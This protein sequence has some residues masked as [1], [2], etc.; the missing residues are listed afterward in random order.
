MINIIGPFDP[1]HDKHKYNT[2]DAFTILA[3]IM[4][5]FT[6]PMMK[7]YKAIRD[8]YPDCLLF[9]RMG[10]FYELFF[11]DATIGAQVLDITL[12]GRPNGKNGRTPMAGV[13][14]HAVDSYLS[15]LVK[16]G[17]KVAI[18][19][20]LS[21]PNKKGLV[22]RDVIRI[23]TPGTL[24]D[25]K[26]LNKK[27]HNYIISLAL[28]GDMLALAT[29]D[30]ST[31]DV[32]TMQVTV[33][34]LKVS[35][36]NELA[37]LHP[38]ECILSEKLY[39]DGEL[40]K[41]LKAEQGLNIFLFREWDTYTSDASTFLKKHFHVKTLAAFGIDDKPLAT[42]A[43]AALIGY[44]KTTQKDNISHIK[45]ISLA[46]DED[47]VVLDRSTMVNLE[48][49][50]TIRDHDTKGSL[51]AVMDNTKTA[52]GG[53]LLRH[54]LLKP[55]TNE[56]EITKRYD[57]VDTLLTNRSLSNQLTELLQQIPDIER[58]VSRLSVGIGNARDL[59]TLKQA[60]ANVIQI[61]SILRHSGFSPESLRKPRK[62]SGPYSQNDGKGSLL[63]SLTSQIS[64]NIE[65][66]ISLI[67]QTIADEP[68]VS[69]REGG[70]IKSGVN[71]QLDKLRKQI[72]GGKEW[73]AELETQE[74]ERTGISSL[75]VRFNKVFGFYIEISK[76]NQHLAPENYI[77]K[78]TL[79][80]GER[81][82]TEELKKQE[83]II[84]RAEAT[85]NDMEY[86]MFQET[87]AK[88][89]EHTEIMKQAAQSI[90]AIDC[91][92]NFAFI[93]QKYNYV[94]PK[95]IYSGELKIKQGR[96][97][98]VEQ[99]LDNT[100][101]VPNDVLLDTNGHQLILITGPNM[102]GKSVFLRQVAL[103][104]LMAQMGSFVPAEQAYVSLVDRIFVR[105]GAADVITSGLSTFM[106][107]MMETAY[108]L[109]NATK[110]SLIIMDEIGRGTSTYDGISI[111]WAVAEYLV[112]N[113]EVT[114]KT[115]FATHY[116]ELT[117]LE[118]KYKDKIK[119]Y[120][121]AVDNQHGDPIFLHSISKGGASHSFGVAVAKLAGVPQ[122]VVDNA[123]KILHSLEDRQST[124]LD[125]T[126]DSIRGLPAT[127]VSR[128]TWPV[129]EVRQRQIP[130]QVRHDKEVDNED[131]IAQT[132][133][134]QSL[135]HEIES[136]EIYKLTP[137][138]AINKIAE[139]QEKL[140]IVTGKEPIIH[141]N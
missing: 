118:D 38:V 91:L 17:Y 25:E 109:N 75:K 78:Q 136:I 98:V 52:M 39:E 3:A 32:E 7:Q 77:R 21:E 101:F 140:K 90:A 107:E 71:S 24:L 37:R 117:S 30:L 35:L 104:S 9:Y 120:H 49:F 1:R 127:V 103:I 40:L 125:V 85:I 83:E 93:S 81:F 47:C 56:A 123:T 54:W 88:V 67:S 114:P 70:L 141:E 29:A 108:I 27:E 86:K 134:D 11:E 132:L 92:V 76:S 121:M 61:K 112:S 23:V 119:N 2:I 15:K 63:Q 137:L 36:Q 116:H 124:P 65:N 139:L 110:N 89:L 28:D 53:R 84:L 97:P 64:P 19:E 68:P 131:L 22:E 135:R 74:R 43:S 130:D 94:R 122:Q 69:L 8:Q 66:V 6:T 20:Q 31:G 115:L 46:K 45:K 128:T 5:P 87:L 34:N 96:H 13:P 48:L 12:T 73:I 106:V 42:Q 138:E 111:A 100:Q 102:A 14:Y 58:I 10:D 59:V 99:L 79:V 51:L 80:N 82:I 33:E 113:P 26:A 16:A 41:I 133:V 60:L 4:N 57:A 62:D 126:P 129:T 55:L 18:C 72:S 50:S 95:L 105:S 44:L